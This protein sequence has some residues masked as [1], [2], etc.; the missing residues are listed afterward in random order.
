MSQRSHTILSTSK[1][2]P[3]RPDTTSMQA[4]SPS[5]CGCT[6]A[7]ASPCPRCAAERKGWSALP[8]GPVCGPLEEQAERV[9]G[10]LD[11]PAGSTASASASRATARVVPTPDAATPR[12]LRTA[13]SAG[14][15]ALDAA[16]RADLEPR[17]GCD[18]SAVRI[19]ADAAAGAAVSSLGTRALTS[20]HHVAFAPGHYA[21]HSPSGRHLLAHE[22]VHAMQQ[23][24]VRRDAPAAATRSKSSAVQN[25]DEVTTKASAP[26]PAA[27]P[28]ISIGQLRGQATVQRDFALPV[29]RPRADARVLTAAQMAAA[30]AFNQRIVAVI[31]TDGISELRDVLGVAPTP[32]VIDE[33]FVR[34]V[35]DWQAAQGI[36]QDG[37][38]GPGTARP[39]FREIGAETAGRAELEKGPSFR[40]TASLTPAVVGGNQRTDFRLETDFKHDPANGI[41]GSCG[42]VRQ[43]IQWDAASAAV[44]PGGIPHG[45]FPAGTAADTWIEDRD[46][47][48]LRYGHRTGPF[49]ESIEINA[50]RDTG[51]RRNAAFGHVFRGRDTPGGPDALLAGHWRFY[52]RAFDVCNGNKVLG[53]DYLRVTW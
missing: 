34:A 49:S 37:Q 50:Y 9:A 15:R 19:H 21:P 4:R 53:T 12:A 25:D 47:V 33:D 52:L 41:Y 11:T 32:A 29:P 36:G 27:L 31:G 24:G 45:G 38:L 46:S 17:L 3:R 5:P 44:L 18:F 40:P 20:G 48:N 8:L 42:E 23:S 16:S 35:V 26:G 51:D 14:G 43:F 7:T 39:L 28:T 22:L 13:L 30:I 6:S 1:S 10:G 2:P